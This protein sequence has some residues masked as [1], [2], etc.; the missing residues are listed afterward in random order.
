MNRIHRRTLLKAGGFSLVLPWFE[1]LARAQTAR[2]RRFLVAY[3]PNGAAADYW[4]SEGVG[5]GSAWQLS[6]L[7]EPFA[8][9]KSKMTV[10]SNLENYSSMQ[11]NP[12][13]EP[14]HARCTGSTSACTTSCARLLRARSR[15]SEPTAAS[16]QAA[17]TA[18]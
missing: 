13:V 10:L 6:P 8:P 12:F 2:P 3:F 9:I 16:K 1:S 14:S 4:P 18:A 17:R 15:A 11:D 5:S 7:L